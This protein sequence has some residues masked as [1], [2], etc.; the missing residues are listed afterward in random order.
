MSSV[1]LPVKVWFTGAADNATT[2]RRPGPD[3]LIARLTNGPPLFSRRHQMR[4]RRACVHNPDATLL[5]VVRQPGRLRRRARRRDGDVRPRVLAVGALQV[6]PHG[7][8][9]W[10]DA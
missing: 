1:I 2:I 9:L 6:I 10:L 4:G 3:A 7:A 5:R 8:V